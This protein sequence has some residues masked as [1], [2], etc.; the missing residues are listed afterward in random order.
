LNAPI[1]GY[2]LKSYWGAG[3]PRQ[4]FEKA[5]AGSLTL[6]TFAADGQMA[7]IA[8]MVTDR[9]TFGWVCDVFVDEGHRGRAWARR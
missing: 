1:T 4:T 5:V 3:I 8:R 7:G 9:A 2:P 6:G